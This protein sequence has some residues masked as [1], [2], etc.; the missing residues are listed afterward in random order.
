VI[1]D[2]RGVK[3]DRRPLT[4][5]EVDMLI[6]CNLAGISYRCCQLYQNLVC[7]PHRFAC[8]FNYD[9]AVQDFTMDNVLCYPGVDMDETLGVLSRRLLAHWLP[10]GHTFEMRSQDTLLNCTSRYMK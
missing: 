10:H 1:E 5:L 6:S 9:Q 3:S 8:M 7:P 2:R 4:L